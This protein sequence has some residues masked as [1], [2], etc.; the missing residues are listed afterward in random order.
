[1]KKKLTAAAVIVAALALILAVSMLGCSKDTTAA[2][3]KT[4][5]TVSTEEAETVQDKAEEPT[6]EVLSTKDTEDTGT[7]TKLRPPVMPETVQKPEEPEINTNYDFA[8]IYNEICQNHSDIASTINASILS[9]PSVFTKED[10]ADLIADL[11]DPIGYDREAAPGLVEYLLNKQSSDSTTAT[12]TTTTDKPSTNTSTS[13]GSNNNSTTSKPSTNTSSNSSSSS[14]SSSNSSSS[15]S[16]YSTGDA[17]WDAMIQNA[18]D[19]GLVEQGN[20][21][22]TSG[23]EIID[24]SDSYVPEW[25]GGSFEVGEDGSITIVGD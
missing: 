1:M 20:D 24:A 4:E 2:E 22:G 9:I 11:I 25:T 17:D 21:P 3:E 16:D 13:T 6:A 14:S 15:G 19:S 8:A 7:D 12:T 10:A 18:I 5:K 23:N